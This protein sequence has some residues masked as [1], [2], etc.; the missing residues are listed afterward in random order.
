MPLPDADGS[1]E[2]RGARAGARAGR[3]RS[4]ALVLGPGL[5]REP[6]AFEL[7]RRLARGAELPLLLDADGLNAHAGALDRARRATARRRC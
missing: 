6:G 1:L 2:P 4:N 3:P 5:G 7:A